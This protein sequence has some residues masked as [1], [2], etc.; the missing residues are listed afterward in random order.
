MF[1]RMGRIRVTRKELARTLSVWLAVAGVKQP[2]LIRDLWT[3]RGEPKDTARSDAAREALA[4]HLAEK[5]EISMHEVTRE[6]PGNRNL[7][8]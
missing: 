1:R 5:F 4:E 2:R 8:G 7:F 3:R 6:D